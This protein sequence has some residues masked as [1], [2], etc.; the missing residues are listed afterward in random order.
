MER[1]GERHS[2]RIN[3]WVSNELTPISVHGCDTMGLCKRICT[4]FVCITDCYD[5]PIS[6]FFDTGDVTVHGNSTSANDAYTG[7]V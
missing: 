3:R 5:L 2:D 4:R 6:M 7:W 1:I